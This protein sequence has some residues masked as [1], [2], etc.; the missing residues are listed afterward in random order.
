MSNPFI[1]FQ[2]RYF[3]S[4]LKHISCVGKENKTIFNVKSRLYREFN[5]L[6]E[7][8]KAAVIN[9]EQRDKALLMMNCIE[10]QLQTL[11]KPFDLDSRFVWKGSLYEKFPHYVHYVKDGVPRTKHFS[12]DEMVT[13][14]HILYNKIRGKKHHLKDG[15]KENEYIH[16]LTYWTDRLAFLYEEECAHQIIPRESIVEISG[17]NGCGDSA[18]TGECGGS[19][20]E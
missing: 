2:I 1:K 14:A 4:Y 16:T 7:S 5:A 3:K 6:Y 20:D 18:Q 19:S 8:T 10:T 17:G 11:Y 13:S 12:E 15:E 9:K